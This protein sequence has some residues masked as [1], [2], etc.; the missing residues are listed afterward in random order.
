MKTGILLFRLTAVVVSLQLILGGLL[1]FDFINAAPHIVLGLI[2]FALAIATTIFAFIGKPAFKPVRGLSVGMVTL[3]IVQIILGFVA[4][5][6][7]SSVIAWIHFVVAL[8]IYGMAVAGIFLAVQ[9]NRMS[10]NP[11]PPAG[12]TGTEKT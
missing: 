5:D 3:I 1:T 8:G 7:G 4:L 9:W 2:V 12:K 10:G 6:T 11:M